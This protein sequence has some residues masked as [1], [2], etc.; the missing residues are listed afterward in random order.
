MDKIIESGKGSYLSLRQT[1]EGYE[2]SHGEKGDTQV[3]ILV[4]SSTREEN[5]I[6]GRFERTPCHFDKRVKLTSFT[7]MVEEG[8]N[9]L[10]TV[11]RELEEESGISPEGLEFIPLGVVHTSKSSDY[12]TDLWAVDVKDRVPGKV[13]GDGTIGEKG[14]YVKWVTAEDYVYNSDDVLVLHMLVRRALQ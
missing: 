12:L 3:A 9:P 7:G 2:Y 8:E 5:P 1:D 4:Y 14:A 13:V 10:E 6:L 11:K